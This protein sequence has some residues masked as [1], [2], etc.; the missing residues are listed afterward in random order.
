MPVRRT[1]SLTKGKLALPRMLWNKN[2]GSEDPPVGAV[3][4]SSLG[5]VEDGNCK[6]ARYLTG[7]NSGNINNAH[8]VMFLHRDQVQ[9]GPILILGEG[10][11]SQ[12]FSFWEKED[13]RK[14]LESLN[15]IANVVVLVPV[16]VLLPV[17]IVV[18]TTLSLSC[19]P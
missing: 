14:C 15:V 4:G 7:D 9:L 5:G 1:L 8:G 11:F 18:S 6:K 2:S 16:L 3:G 19:I 13:F 12:V 17:R 10:G